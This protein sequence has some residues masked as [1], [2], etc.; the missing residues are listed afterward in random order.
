M[1]QLHQ[2][3]RS[4]ASLSDE[5][6]TPDDL[7][8]D[9]CKFTFLNPELDVCATPTNSKCEYFLTKYHDA[10]TED[11]VVGS[12]NVDVWCNPPHSK[13]R[14]FVERVNK[15]WWKHN[16]NIIMLV[17]ANA[18]TAKYFDDI[19]DT[20]QAEYHR[21]SGRIRFLVNGEPSKYPSRNGYFVVIWRER[22]A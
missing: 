12:R 5:Y 14:Q 17:P 16:I 13:T 1:S 4:E 19:F 3:K 7:F 6:E 15:Q 10:L 8:W 21:I 11:W 22:I 2:R 18:I 20:E 9:I